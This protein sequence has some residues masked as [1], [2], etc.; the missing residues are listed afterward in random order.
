VKKALVTHKTIFWASSTPF[1]VFDVGPNFYFRYVM[2]QT[3]C[4]AIVQT[5]EN[6]AGFASQRGNLSIPAR[7]TKNIRAESLGSWMFRRPAVA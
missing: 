5:N 2:S 4:G 6:D 7:Q 1:A 3:F